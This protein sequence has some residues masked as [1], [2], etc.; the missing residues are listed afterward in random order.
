MK[1]W[2]FCCL[3]SPLSVF[4]CDFSAGKFQKI[5]ESEFSAELQ[6]AK[7]GT[8]TLTRESWMPGQLPFRES[9]TWRGTWECSKNKLTLH[10]VGQSVEG[11]WAEESLSGAG[12]AQTA[13]SLH[14][15]AQNTQDGL[16]D[17]TSFWP[18]AINRRFAAMQAKL[19]LGQKS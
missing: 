15:S 1:K 4:A 9:H 17:G 13:K 3:L 7:N 19:S 12:L 2:L 16:F 11:Y 18:E 14:F 5:T 6:L 10:Y 8:F